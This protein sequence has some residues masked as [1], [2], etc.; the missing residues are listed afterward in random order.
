MHRSLLTLLLFIA[1][2]VSH[3]QNYPLRQVNTGTK[4]SFRGLSATGDGAVWVSGKGCVGRSTN[5][6]DD[7][8][9]RPVPGYEQCDFRSLY[10]FDSNNAVIA[11]AGSPAYILRTADGGATWKVVYTNTD[12]AAF[13]D[14]VGFWNR[15]H[16]IMH[17]DPI[18]GRMLLLTTKD[19]GKT[20]TE[21]KEHCKPKMNAGE[22]SFAASG[23][24]IS[25]VADRKVVVATGGSTARLLIS[26]NRGRRWQT[27]PTPMRA[28]QPSMGIFSFMPTQ[29]VGHWLIAGGDYKQDT[30]CAANFFYTLDKGKTWQAP[31]N[32]T[33][34]YRECLAQ[35]ENVYPVKKTLSRTT[36]AVGPSGI[37]VS[38]DDGVNWIPLS[39]ERDFHVIKPSP[40]QDRLY[41]AGGNGKVAVMRVR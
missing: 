29:F 36:F 24:S 19:G 38:G 20:W 21:R 2:T 32:T 13:I 8:T 3:A 25:C 17:G 28:G 18:N 35:I 37:D 40:R 6:G 12:T 7:W 27:V 23:T 15:K 14:G 39:N 31:A 22:A 16:G 26:R 30:A 9:F 1:V 33:R 4:G 11:N 5:N 41:L 10:A 34:G